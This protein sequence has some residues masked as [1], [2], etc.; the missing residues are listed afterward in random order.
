MPQ[1]IKGDNCGLYSVLMPVIVFAVVFSA[2]PIDTFCLLCISVAFSDLMYSAMWT[3]AGCTTGCT[4]SACVMCWHV[5]I[6]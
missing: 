6:F 3:V 5:Y 4:S 1:V 2:L